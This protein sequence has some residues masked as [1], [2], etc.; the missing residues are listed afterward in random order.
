MFLDVS[1]AVLFVSQPLYWVK[2]EMKRKRYIP[3]FNVRFTYQE[4][5]VNEQEQQHLSTMSCCHR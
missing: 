4:E 2:P 5:L 3:Q 1:D